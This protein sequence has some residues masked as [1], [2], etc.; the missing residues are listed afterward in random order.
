MSNKRGPKIYIGELT[1]KSGGKAVKIG[2]TIGDPMVRLTKYAAQYGYEFSRET[3]K[4][5]VF[6]VTPAVMRGVEFALHNTFKAA[7]IGTQEVFRITF[8]TAV[9]AAER[10][11]AQRG[12]TRSE[13][14]AA[15]DRRCGAI[16]RSGRPCRTKIGPDGRCRWHG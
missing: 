6:K 2:M 7:R 3:A 14:G 9:K 12:E 10:I 15:V 5:A 13:R 8:A 1:E 11:I 4:V 16:T